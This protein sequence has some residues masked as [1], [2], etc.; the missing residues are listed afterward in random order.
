MHRDENLAVCSQMVTPDSGGLFCGHTVKLPVSAALDTSS[1]AVNLCR[2]YPWVE[3][4]ISTFMLQNTLGTR[5]LSSVHIRRRF[6]DNSRQDYIAH[7][8]ECPMKSDLDSLGFPRVSIQNIVSSHEIVSILAP[9]LWMSAESLPHQTVEWA[10]GLDIPA[11]QRSVN[12][13]IKAIQVCTC[14]AANNSPRVASVGI[15]FLAISK[16]YASLSG[17]PVE[18]PT[19]NERSRLNRNSCVSSSSHPRICTVL[20]VDRDSSSLSSTSL[21]VWGRYESRR[22]VDARWRGS[23]SF[24]IWRISDRCESAAQEIVLRSAQ[25]VPPH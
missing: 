16:K 25:S 13:Q 8:H 4:L 11:E 15:P 7:V 21:M 22:A 24:S 5:L 12:Q 6:T 9:L 14:P 23:R 18:R 2:L 3:R 17:W 1:F 20:I 10:R 19:V